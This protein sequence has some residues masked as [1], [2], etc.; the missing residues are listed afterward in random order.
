MFNVANELTKSM[1]Q[2]DFGIDGGKVGLSRGWCINNGINEV[3]SLIM[4]VVIS[5][6]IVTI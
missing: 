6:R 1:K 4:V 3:I 2:V 5:M